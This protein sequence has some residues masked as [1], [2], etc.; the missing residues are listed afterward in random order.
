MSKSTEVATQGSTELDAAKDLEALEAELAAENQ[1]E[2][3]ARDLQIPLLKI[4]QGLT[5]EV[6]DG[7]AKAGEFIN[8]LTRESLGTQVDFVVASFRKGR[9]DHG[10]R[11]KKI[12]ARKAYGVKNVPWNDD[13][14]YGRPFTDHP[15]AE[16]KYAERVNRGDL[17]WGKGPRI[18][19]TFDFTGFVI[20]TDPDEAPIPVVLSLMRKN[21]KQAQKWV[22]ILSAILRNRYWDAVFTLSTEQQRNDDGTYYT[23]NVKQSRK[24][25]ADERMDAIQLADRVRKLNVEVV[26]EDE[27]T[28]SAPKAEPDAA[29]GMAV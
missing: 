9:F 2:I 18:S 7:D 17:P 5:T 21:K 14:F 11:E 12:R 4:G 26:G 24:T 19:T 29:G 25:N 10:N 13:P 6:I 3:E 20:P 28:S 1:D 15:D 8:A 23:I 16:E 27:E 22:T